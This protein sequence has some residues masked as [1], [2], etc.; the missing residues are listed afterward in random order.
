MSDALFG[1]LL[2]I[3]ATITVVGFV[4]AFVRFLLGPSLPDRVAAI[5]AMTLIAAGFLVI[6]SLRTKEPLLLDIALAI[7]LIAFLGTV[8]LGISIQRGIFK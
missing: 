3:P 5:D 6:I 2:W 7:T 8:A 4:L 1:Q